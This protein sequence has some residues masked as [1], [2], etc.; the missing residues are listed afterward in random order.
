MLGQPAYPLSLESSNGALIL[1]SIETHPI[2]VQG[3]AIQSEQSRPI[4]IYRY[5]TSG[6]QDSA[7]YLKSLDRDGTNFSV[8]AHV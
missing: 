2:L 4:Y 5:I 8:E 3:W 7:K 1:P 6:S